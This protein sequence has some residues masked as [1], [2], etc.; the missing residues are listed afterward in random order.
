LCEVFA[1]A[2][3]MLKTVLYVTL[4]FGT[5]KTRCRLCVGGK[6]GEL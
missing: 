3:K 2:A 1:P 5:C 4:L 6:V